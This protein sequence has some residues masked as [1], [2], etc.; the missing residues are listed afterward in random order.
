MSDYH[1]TRCMMRDYFDSRFVNCK[2][3]DVIR[4]VNITKAN[5]TDTVRGV[6]LPK[7]SHEPIDEDWVYRGRDMLV[8]ALQRGHVH[9]LTD[10]GITHKIHHGM[11]TE[12][13]W[14]IDVKKAG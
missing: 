12:N 11:L 14:D 1:M 3:G 9:V 4:F 7:G 6:G 8:V 2:V 13:T 10:D 5:L